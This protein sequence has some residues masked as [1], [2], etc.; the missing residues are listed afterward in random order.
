[1]CD[2][3]ASSPLQG[4]HSAKHNGGR[5][6]RRR[7]LAHAGRRLVPSRRSDQDELG[8]HSGGR[9]SRFVPTSRRVGTTQDNL[10]AQNTLSLPS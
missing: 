9:G 10:P 3:L 7:S 2:G 1:M 5:S 4:K 8:M 6:L